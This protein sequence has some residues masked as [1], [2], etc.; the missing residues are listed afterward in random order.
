MFSVPAPVATLAMALAVGRASTIRLVAVA[1]YT[2]CDGPN[3]ETDPGVPELWLIAFEN[4]YPAPYSP[5]G[6]AY[7]VSGDV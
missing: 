7:A 1:P 2:V 3:V 6:G 5:T 4:P